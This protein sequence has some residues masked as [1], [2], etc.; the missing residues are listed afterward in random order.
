MP[1]QRRLLSGLRGH[2]WAIQLKTPSQFPDDD[3]PRLAGIYNWLNGLD[4]PEC[5]S[6]YRIAVF[7]TRAQAREARKKLYYAPR[8]AVVRKIRGAYEILPERPDQRPARFT[9]EEADAEDGEQADG[10]A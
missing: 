7:E 9:K 8:R 2:A 4:V 5:M 1:R 6:G 10:T 3:A